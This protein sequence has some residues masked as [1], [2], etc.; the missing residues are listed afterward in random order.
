LPYGGIF[1]LAHARCAGA[2][3]FGSTSGSDR[4]RCI[5]PVVFRKTGPRGRR[6]GKSDEWLQRH[7]WL[8]R[9]GWSFLSVRP[10]EGEIR[11]N[12]CSLC[13]GE[14]QDVNA[15]WTTDYPCLLDKHCNIMA[16]YNTP[17]NAAEIHRLLA[18]GRRPRAGGKRGTPEVDRS[19]G[20]GLP[21]R[22]SIPAPSAMCP[23][24][25]HM[26]ATCA[27]I[28]YKPEAQMRRVCVCAA[29]RVCALGHPDAC[30]CA[31]VRA[32]LLFPTLLWRRGP[33]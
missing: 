13:A 6:S 24:C 26:C 19:T 23:A 29:C 28:G 21:S 18:G 8:G 17:R 27:Q 25:A 4:G 10:D 20:H 30:V 11:V 2:C 33:L 14:S 3:R 9:R 22:V 1:Q 7:T 31:R 32:L 15:V 12:A 16:H 5:W